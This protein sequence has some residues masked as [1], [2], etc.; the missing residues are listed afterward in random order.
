ML[1]VAFH[2]ACKQSK[3]LV[4]KFLGCGSELSSASH[5]PQTIL[6][7]GKSITGWASAHRLWESACL[8]VPLRKLHPGGLEAT[9]PAGHVGTA[10]C[11]LFESPQEKGVRPGAGVCGPNATLAE[12]APFPHLHRSPLHTHTRTRTYTHMH[13]HPRMQMI[14]AEPSLVKLDRK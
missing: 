2:K 3:F 13:A 14:T 5:L 4:I 9:K 12:K 7:S 8:G 10:S 1:V 6:L 11:L